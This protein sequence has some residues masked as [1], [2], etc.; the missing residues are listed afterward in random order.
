MRLNRVI[1]TALLTSLGAL[2]TACDTYC[3]K[4]NQVEEDF[5]QTWIIHPSDVESYSLDTDG[6][7][8]SCEE[9][10]AIA[11]DSNLS[12]YLYNLYVDACTTDV[13]LPLG[14]PEAADTADTALVQEPAYGTVSCAGRVIGTTNP[15]C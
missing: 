3:G 9:L 7:I 12:V 5:D 13:P 1:H 11:V 4:L 2:A 6:R 15:G 8:D 14:E 10:C